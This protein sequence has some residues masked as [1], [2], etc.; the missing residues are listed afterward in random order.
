MQDNKK[1]TKKLTDK[2]I[3]LSAIITLTIVFVIV[4]FFAFA[5]LNLKEY[6]SM[7]ANTNQV[8]VYLNDL[9]EDTKNN[10]S[11][12]IIELPGVSSIRYESK[13]IAL[14]IAAKELGVAI[15]ESENPLNDAFFVYLNKSVKLDQLKTSLLNMPEISAVDFRTKALEKNINFSKGIDSL[16]VKV[17]VVST[18]IC[19]FMIYNIVSFSIKT[20]KKEIHEFL[21]EGVK[22]KVL[23]KTFFLESV[24]VIFLSTLI[25][26]GLYQ[27]IRQL[28][29][30]NIKQILPSYTTTVSILEEASVAIV[31]FVAAIIISAIISFFAMNRYFKIKSLEKIIVEENDEKED[32]TSTEEIG[33]ED[34]NN[35]EV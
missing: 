22:A 14:K 35:W 18:V 19:L 25:S 7:Q 2:G 24:A 33:D 11:Q 10:L 4:E 1:Y 26:F 15:D 5:L 28:L 13:E 30:K 23:K 3:F 32:A 8:I 34:E 6:S 16:S 31:L 9:D 12:K 21:E 29:V 27:L 20:R 17:A